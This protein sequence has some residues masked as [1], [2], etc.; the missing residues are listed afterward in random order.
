MKI[1]LGV[2][3]QGV[4]GRPN[5]GRPDPRTMKLMLLESLRDKKNKLEEQE[6]EMDPEMYKKQMENL[7]RALDNANKMPTDPKQIEKDME[8]KALKN[9]RETAKQ[10][11]EAIAKARTELLRARAEN[12]V[13][14]HIFQMNIN[15]MQ[16]GENQFNKMLK[17]DDEELI[18]IM[19]EMQQKA[20]QM[21]QMQR[22]RQMQMQK[23]QAEMAA[24]KKAAEEE[25]KKELKITEIDE[26]A[27]EEINMDDHEG[28]NAEGSNK[29]NA[30]RRNNKAE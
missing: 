10:Q 24:R 12:R 22:Q 15:R 30:R 2:G 4:K 9:A 21:Q 28:K 27:A 29:K 8:Q 26:D 3:P 14:D 13:P 19:K 11:L 16:A 20:M 25:A 17:A 5:Q 23:Q 18:E 1:K 6:S 7:E